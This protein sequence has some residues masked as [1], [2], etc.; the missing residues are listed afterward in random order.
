[1]KT[2][3]LCD[4]I[5]EVSMIRSKWVKTH[6]AA[7]RIAAEKLVMFMFYEANINCEPG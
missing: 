5:V 4:Y 3:Y 7:K 6:G 1:M 2:M